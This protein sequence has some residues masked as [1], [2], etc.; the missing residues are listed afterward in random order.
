MKITHAIF[1]FL[2][3]YAC[4]FQA[5]AQPE[6]NRIIKEQQNNDDAARKENNLVKKDVY[7]TI[8]KK[9]N[10]I[11]EFPVE[12]NCF[13]INEIV[14]ED[15]FLQ[16]ASLNQLKE[17]IV[18]RCMGMQGLEKTVSLI[19]DYFINAGYITT[20]IE[21]P[22]QDLSLNKLVLK[23]IPGKID[24]IKIENNDIYQYILPFKKDDILNIR[25]IEQGLENLQRVPGVDVKIG[26]TPGSRNGYSNVV[27]ATNRYRSWNL[28]A[29]YN[30]WGDKSTG[31]QLAGG[32]GYLYNLTKTNDI[33][34]VS[35]TTSTTGNYKSISTYY[36]IPFGYWDYELFYSSSASRQGFS[37]ADMDLSYRGENKYFSAKAS[38]TLFRN[39]DK[40]ITGTAELIRRKADYKL[41]DI[42]L[43]L[44]KR[45]MGNVRF[46]LHYK[47]NS[48]GAALNGSLTYQRFLTWFGGTP[49]SDMKTGEVNEA[50]HIVNLDLN[51][52]RLL[53]YGSLDA[54]YNMKFGAQYAPNPLTLQDQF[55]IGSRWN[56]R[57][58]ENS[59]GLYGDKGFY[60]QNTINFMTSYKAIEPYIGIDYGQI[61]SSAY[62]HNSGSSQ[63]I[64]GAV[65]GI[66][67]GTGALGYDVSLSTPLISPDELNIDKFTINFHVFYQL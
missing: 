13:L 46:G 4:H 64:M 19:Q 48:P 53:R 60:L 39:S 7:S 31:R 63:K 51:Y 1:C 54:Y 10:D 67:G 65:A 37:I 16:R 12:E 55:T 38:R 26:I 6:L 23:V 52:T 41:N 8:N 3:T 21:I 17:M 28:R 27:I 66:K 25:D 61:S 49:T 42:A 32:V 43:L 50:S 20:R 47:Q 5:V 22:E 36:S 18:R 34:Y 2:T 35:G 33:F 62:T 57:G 56:V 45:D 40:K 14:L 30:N 24:E 58:F 15:N 11:A 9:H 59:S 44:Q 29:T